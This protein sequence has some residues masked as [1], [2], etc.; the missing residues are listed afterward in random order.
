M[1]QA[2]L[3]GSML[4]GFANLAWAQ[5]ADIHT[6]CGESGSNFNLAVS[7]PVFSYEATI[8]G[9]TVAFMATLEVY[10]NGVL[11]EVNAQTVLLPQAEYA[12]A[13]PVDMSSWGLKPGDTVTFRL[14]VVRLGLGGLLAS[15]SL[16]GDVTPAQTGS[17][18]Q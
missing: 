6:R 15:H 5:G 2:L 13:A 1:K 14:K 8:S 9:C 17:S 16:T 18:T 4:F 11:K 12:F 3:V 10:H 7:T